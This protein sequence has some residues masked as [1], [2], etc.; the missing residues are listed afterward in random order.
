MPAKP[1]SGTKVTEPSGFNVAL[2]AAGLRF[3]IIP[4]EIV[5][6]FH[7]LIKCSF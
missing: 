1:E 6:V 2:P 5:L 3:I 4:M 7:M